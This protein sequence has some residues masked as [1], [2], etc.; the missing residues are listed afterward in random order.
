LARDRL[1]RAATM[2]F[3]TVLV[4]FLTGSFALPLT[5]PARD[6]GY[7]DGLYYGLRL[8]GESDGA[9]TLKRAQP[10]ASYAFRYGTGPQLLYVKNLNKRVGWGLETGGWLFWNKDADID[11]L[12]RSFKR[13]AVVLP[14]LANVH[15]S[16][17]NTPRFGIFLQASGGLAYTQTIHRY[18]GRSRVE[19]Q[20]TGLYG[21]TAVIFIGLYKLKLSPGYYAGHR[22]GTSYF[23]LGGSAVHSVFLPVLLGDRQP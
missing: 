22:F 1:G 5:C 16:L 9:F 8:L 7:R 21:L 6:R 19:Q 3:R 17:I 15:V 20:T 14:A 4:I 23:N 2:S 18:D 13:R 11:D 12:G 10:M